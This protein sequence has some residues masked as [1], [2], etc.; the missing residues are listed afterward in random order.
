MF[1]FRVFPTEIMLNGSDWKWLGN[2]LGN[3][4]AT[5]L[6]SNETH[7]NLQNKNNVKPKNSDLNY[8]ICI[9]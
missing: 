9:S 3:S 6:Y 8:I 4:N 1:D 2:Y 7:N 5:V